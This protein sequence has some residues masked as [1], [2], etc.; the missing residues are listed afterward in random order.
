[1]KRPSLCV[2][3]SS[4]SDKFF[5]I[6]HK[7]HIFLFVS[8]LLESTHKA[9][10]FMSHA[11]VSIRRNESTVE[12]FNSLKTHVV[13]NTSSETLIKPFVGSSSITDILNK[14]SENNITTSD[15]LNQLC[16]MMKTK[17]IT[18]TKVTR[19]KKK[20]SRF[21]LDSTNSKLLWRS[22]TKSLLLDC[23]KDIRVGHM[24][25]NYCEEYGISDDF[26]S[27]WMTIIYTINKK[28]KGL[29][30]I[31]TT[32]SD[33]DNLTNCIGGLVKLRKEL[34]KSLLLP[35]N[36]KFANIHW[37]NTVSQRKEDEQ[38]DTLTFE[39]V[40]KLCDKFHIFC[41]SEYL[42]RLFDEADINNNQLL[43]FKEFQNFV[44]LL[45][46][47]KEMN[48]IWE[49][50]T[51]NSNCLSYEMF[52]NF[53]IHVQKEELDEN[54]FK[55]L[56][57]NYHN[58][59]GYITKDAFIR[60]LNDQ[61][62]LYEELVDYSR[63]LNHYFIA[64]SHNTYLLGKQFAET[65]SVEGYIQVLQQG[66]RC[67]EIDIWDGESGPVVCHGILTSSIPLFNVIQVI[68]KYAFIT[69][70]YPLI[71]S[72]ETHCDAPNQF[73]TSQLFKDILGNL[74]YYNHLDETNLPSPEQLKHK[75]ILKVKKPKFFL[76]NYTM[77][78]NDLSSGGKQSSSSIYEY[79][80]FSSSNDSDDKSI[81]SVDSAIKINTGLTR[82]RRISLKKKSIDTI[83]EM[84]DICGI[85]G[86]KFRNFSLPESKT[87]THCF[88]IN[89]KNFE[90]MCKDTTQRL[91]IDKHNR[92]YLMRVY[93]H[94]MRYYSS[95]FNPIIFWE[96]GVQMVATNWQTKDLGQQ[97]NLAMFR[98]SNQKND[99][100]Y[101]GFILKP[102]KLLEPINKIKD[103]PI[104]YDTIK[105]EN[106]NGYK[107][108]IRILSGQLLPKIKKDPKLNKRF[109]PSVILEFI[110]NEDNVFTPVKILKN[111]SRINN[112]SIQTLQ[113][114]GNG[115]NPIWE[116][117]C[118]VSILNLDFAFIKFTVI[119]NDIP[120]ATTCLKLEY[121]KPGYRPIPLY[122]LDGEQ[123]IFSTLFVYSQVDII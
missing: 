36:V 34:M 50:V 70:P 45:K 112:T 18:L 30:V 17:G 52:K 114:D 121:L 99:I 11:L 32:Q 8:A 96:S 92:R 54:R 14:V 29:H 63:P 95:N 66:C 118:N 25:S 56:F 122:N 13:N 113:C 58:K 31:A 48:K 80:S 86:L 27:R 78:E 97:I 82:I 81:K 24:A 57:D 41:S 120:L 104:L 116:L 53:L 101:S 26:I 44:S 75:I 35:D 123:Y 71:I 72:L 88:S 110:N 6:F 68:K 12:E 15:K 87:T 74:I 111:A 98:L 106:P 7:F 102:K 93:P 90:S 62:H 51:Q 105:N 109:G 89:E 83:K 46:E 33:L 77:G 42:K 94:A 4:Q 10:L 39:Q 79:S 91:C 19:T 40:R 115:F 67:V 85:Y 76:H 55:Q 9:V 38:K 60:F 108:T 3:V 23:I 22:D 5:D 100:K 65:P 117:E 21:K 59:D 61:N 119:T 49:N 1:M 43:N 73:I 20:L 2:R 16:N 47:R 103:I 64:S 84:F 69:S 107:I 37:R 28:L